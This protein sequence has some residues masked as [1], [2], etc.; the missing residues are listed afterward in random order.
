MPRVR[1]TLLGI[2]AL[3]VIS[4]G[5][6][7]YINSGGRG[8]LPPPNTVKPC[9]WDPAQYSPAENTCER[10]CGPPYKASDSPWQHTIGGKVYLFCC[11][12]GYQLSIANNDPACLRL[13]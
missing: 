3:A 11:P 9:K 6:L 2:L 10:R 5:T 4:V 1:I 7:L 8:K 13:K 12:K